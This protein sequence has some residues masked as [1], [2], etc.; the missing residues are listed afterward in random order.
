MM[1]SIEAIKENGIIGAG[2]AG[3]PTYLKLSSQAEIF[4]VNA[5]ECEPLL[6]KDKEILLRRVGPFLKGLEIAKKLVGAKRCIIG[7]K[8]KYPGLVAHLKQHCHGL[9]EIFLL[10]DFYPAGDE[11]TLIYETTGRVVN[12]G[13]LPITKNVMVN[14]VETLYNIGM[15]K[16]VVSKFITIGGDVASPRTV[17]VPIGISIGEVVQTARPNRDEFAVVIG[18]PMMGVLADDM[19]VPV[20]KTTGGLLVFHKGHV[21]VDRLQTAASEAR[22]IAI[23]KSACD[24]C[25]FCTELCPRYLLGHPIQPHKSMRT[26]IYSGPTLSRD[27]LSTTSL[28]CCE[29]NLCSLI[30]CP[31][32]LYPAQAC[33]Y[34]K[35]QLMQDKKKYTGPQSG[36]VHPLI[37]YR[38]TPSSKIMKRLDLERY[39]NKGPL[40]PFD[41]QPGQVTLKLDQHIGV[42]AAPM[43]NVGDAVTAGQKIASVGDQLGAE[44][45]SPFDG[46]VTRVEKQSICIKVANRNKGT[47]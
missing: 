44:L 28:Y 10:D 40:T 22:V 47:S 15:Q 29:C 30:S 46:L 18:G 26:L 23:G 19:N 38:R 7:I 25:I 39:V 41:N 9:A 12:A 27:K 14:N 42:P 36:G 8:A 31:E 20:T 24:Q 5:A 16:P 4:I 3:F 1:A 32:G 33:I 21:L 17:E 2:G 35:K 6:H 43:V 37:A 11:I 13:Q 45:H 34:S